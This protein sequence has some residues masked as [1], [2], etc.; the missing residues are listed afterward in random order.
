[1]KGASNKCKQL[2]FR[3]RVE[4]SGDGYLIIPELWD[5]NIAILIAEEIGIRELNEMRW[6]IIHYVRE[7][8]KRNGRSPFVFRQK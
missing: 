8:W 2:Q 4:F 3:I 7:Y 1:L 6:L 5:E